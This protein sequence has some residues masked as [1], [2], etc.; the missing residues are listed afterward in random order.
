MAHGALRILVV[1]HL[2]YHV[3]VGGDKVHIREI[4]AKNNQCDLKYIHFHK[5]FDN[6]LFYTRFASN[7]MLI[8]IRKDTIRNFEDYDTS[9]C[10]VYFPDLSAEEVYEKEKMRN[11]VAV[12][13]RIKRLREITRIS[14]DDE[15]L[16]LAVYSV[17]H[18]YGHWI[19]FMKVGPIAYNAL[20]KKSMQEQ[21]T[22]QQ[23]NN[24]LYRMSDDHPLKMIYA[25]EAVRK[26]EQLPQERIAIEYT[27][28]E[29]PSCYDLC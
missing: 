27:M 17:L 8:D 6:N 29:F 14:Q 22:V 3:K 28:K 19:D 2:W 20:F 21:A 18:E 9:E 16:A 15:A 12:V 23:L 25:E 24:E 13:Y 10:G 11:P 7:D 4:V 26:Y 1:F 5:R